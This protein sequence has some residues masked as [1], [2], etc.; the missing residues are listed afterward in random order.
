MKASIKQATSA[1]LRVH[2]QDEFHITGNWH[3]VSQKLRENFAELT[4]ADVAL[5]SGME[6]QLLTRLAKRLKIRRDEVITL[7]QQLQ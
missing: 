3:P 6:E 5:N 2:S 1:K 7:I 4:E